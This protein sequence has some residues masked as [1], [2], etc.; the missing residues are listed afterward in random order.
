MRLANCR[1]VGLTVGR[2]V[3]SP[4]RL[5]GRKDG[6]GRSLV[7]ADNDD[8]DVFAGSVGQASSG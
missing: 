4:E 6:D 3:A 5:Y 8:M 1:P 2:P 7:Q